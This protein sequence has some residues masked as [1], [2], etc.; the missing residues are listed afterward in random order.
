MLLPRRSN[1]KVDTDF[2]AVRSR[3]T[4]FNSAVRALIEL[5]MEPGA[6]DPC[7]PV[8][9][10]AVDREWELTEKSLDADLA[11]LNDLVLMATGDFTLSSTLIKSSVDNPPYPLVE[12]N[13]PE[14]RPYPFYRVTMTLRRGVKYPLVANKLLHKFIKELDE[15]RDMFNLESLPAFIEYQGALSNN[16]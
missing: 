14:P 10:D 16:K 3:I 12:A 11:A 1:N 5:Q 15:K 4:M 9:V 2:D 8:A 7:F 6:L 13:R